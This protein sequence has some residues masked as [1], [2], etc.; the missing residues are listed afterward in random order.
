MSRQSDPLAA[1]Q[2]QTRTL[3]SLR[4]AISDTAR[5]RKISLQSREKVAQTSSRLVLL[6]VSVVAKPA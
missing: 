4:T 3:L 1:I 2:G 6:V 5:A